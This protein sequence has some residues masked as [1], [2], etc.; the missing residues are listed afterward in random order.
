MRAPGRR[1]L[2]CLTSGLLLASVA[3]AQAQ[4]DG[5]LCLRAFEDRDADGNLD[6]GEPLLTAGVNA[7]L[8]DEAGTVVAGG[9][10]DGSPTAAQGV[11]CFQFLQPG[12]YTLL[13]S[14]PARTATGDARFPLRIEAG[15]PPQLVDYGAGA[16]TGPAP[17]TAA[18]STPDLAQQLPRIGLATLGA[19]LVMTGM[20]CVGALIGFFAL[21]R[22]QASSSRARSGRRR[23]PLRH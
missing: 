22:R 10:M 13:V 14:S 20:L 6:S 21:R 23:E 16:L 15:S 9:Q 7:E 18:D 1:L 17:S 5:H 2:L 12:D 8:R 11:L 19:L 3:L 4:A